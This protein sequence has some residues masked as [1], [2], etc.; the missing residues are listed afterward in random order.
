MITVILSCLFSPFIIIFFFRFGAVN[1]FRLGLLWG[2]M[3]VWSIRL[4][5]NYLRRE[6]WTWGAREV[7]LFSLFFFCLLRFFEGFSI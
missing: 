4:T 5:H 2:I 7:T 3:L 6:E 1:S